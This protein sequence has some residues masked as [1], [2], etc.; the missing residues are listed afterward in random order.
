MQDFKKA[1]FNRK[2]GSCDCRVLTALLEYFKKEFSD[3][4]GDIY[5]AFV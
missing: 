1:F 3:Q 5:S 4:N 2:S